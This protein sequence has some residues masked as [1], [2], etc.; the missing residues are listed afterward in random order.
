[1]GQGIRKILLMSDTA[2]SILALFIPDMAVVS[3]AIGIAAKL[4]REEKV[5][6]MAQ[7]ENATRIAVGTAMDNLPIGKRAILEQIYDEI[8]YSED[9]GE[10]IC[11]T[12]AFRVSYYTE[13]DV[14]EIIDMF[15]KCLREAIAYFD[16]LSRWYTLNCHDVTLERV[17]DIYNLLQSISVIEGDTNQKVNSVVDF[18]GYIRSLGKTISSSVV[19]IAI[20]IFIFMMGAII[21]GGY[22]VY[23]TPIAGLSLV[24]SEL[25]VNSVYDKHSIFKPKV[26]L[27]R[28]MIMS[29]ITIEN[30]VITIMAYGIVPIGITVASFLFM[31]LSIDNRDFRLLFALAGL[32]GGNIVGVFIKEMF[33]ERVSND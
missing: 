3:K 10:L 7:L 29:K 5:S 16:V 15:D 24:V 1:M 18:M 17:K 13:K 23:I 12:E 22:P 31:V 20:P 2:F 6:I 21:F 28:D 19:F 8:V 9:L 33:F 11:K 14:K 30:I 27:T 25:V 32:V 26:G 4:T